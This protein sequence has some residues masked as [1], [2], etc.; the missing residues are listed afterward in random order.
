MGSRSS[1]SSTSNPTTNYADNRN[2]IDAGG[3]VAGTGNQWDQSVSYIDN[4]RTDW[5]STAVSDS[6]NTTSWTDGSTTNSAWQW[7][8]SQRTEV[9][10]SGNTSSNWNWDGS[11]RSSTSN[12]DNSTRTNTNSGNTS[13]NS[14]T[15]NNITDGGAFEMMTRVGLA[16]TEA[17]RGIAR[18]G[19]DASSAASA[20]AI[21]AAAAANTAASASMGA[22]MQAALGFAQAT[23][24]QGYA[25]NRE[26]MGMQFQAFNGLAK[27]SG[28]VVQAAARQADNATSSARAA[29]SNAQDSAS[30]TRTLMYAGLAVVAVVFLMRKT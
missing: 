23:S 16:Q 5:T 29:F 26:A 8:G 14:N 22:S 2:V 12:T 10:D 17:A 1:S 3:G 27:L 28:D 11:D 20:Q 21:Q 13:W 18:A 4:G 6:G 25:S 30:G 9:R 15:T 7:D 19:I 24:A